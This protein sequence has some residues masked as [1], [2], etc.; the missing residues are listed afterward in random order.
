M[1]TGAGNYPPRTSGEK[2]N[3][4]L[5][6]A[7]Q[8]CW[9]YDCEVD[10]RYN[11]QPIDRQFMCELNKVLLPTDSVMLRLDVGVRPY[12]YNRH[13]FERYRSTHQ[14]CC[15]RTASSPNTSRTVTKD[16]RGQRKTNCQRSAPAMAK[17]N[18]ITKPHTTTV[19]TRTT[20]WNYVYN[21]R[22]DVAF[23]QEWIEKFGS[24]LADSAGKAYYD[25]GEEDAT[26]IDAELDHW[27]TW[28]EKYDAIRKQCNIILSDED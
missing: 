24:R 3:R 28:C 21:E 14:S 20:S 4:A 12:L 16:R 10:V 2:N 19:S 9:G 15:I 27:L 25:R 1:G 8:Y 5:R 7:T 18:E 6:H 22:G 17:H 26:P 11:T 23:W 13:A